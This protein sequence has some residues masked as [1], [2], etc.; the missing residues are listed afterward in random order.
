MPKINKPNKT[1][2]VSNHFIN[3]KI[4]IENYH[5][6]YKY[7]YK[8]PFWNHKFPVYY[9]IIDCL[10]EAFYLSKIFDHYWKHFIYYHDT[11]DY[12]YQIYLPV[13]KDVKIVKDPG[14]YYFIKI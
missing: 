6:N 14:C 11:S 3:K 13:T 2:S 12:N 8:I 4:Q 9:H 5:H 10:T 7:K 1:I